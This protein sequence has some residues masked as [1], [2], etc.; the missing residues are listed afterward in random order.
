V[1][2]LILNMAVLQINAFLDRFVVGHLVGRFETE[3]HGSYGTS[4]AQFLVVRL[5]LPPTQEL[6]IYN[7]LSITHSHVSE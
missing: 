6:V 1:Q 2:L 7:G 3:R 4:H 5:I